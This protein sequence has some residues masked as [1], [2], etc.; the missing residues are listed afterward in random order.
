MSEAQTVMP[1]GA[2]SGPVKA[3]SGLPAGTGIAASAFAGG[4]GGPV[5][6]SPLLSQ[7]S[8]ISVSSSLVQ[9]AAA[10]LG[11][12]QGQG[13]APVAPKRYLRFM[14]VYNGKDGAMSVDMSMVLFKVYKPVTVCVGWG[15]ML[16]FWGLGQARDG[17]Y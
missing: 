10:G 8:S 4:P 5:A 9:A 13:Q 1:G 11:Q 14:D 2:V 15:G 17:V 12:G 3:V 6:T 7:V 16:R